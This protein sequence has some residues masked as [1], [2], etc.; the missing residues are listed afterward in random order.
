VRREGKAPPRQTRVFHH[1]GQHRAEQR[2]IEQQEER[3]ARVRDVHRRD[4]AVAEVLLRKQ[5][6]RAIQV[7]NK[8]VR[9]ER[10]SI[11]QRG[12]PGVLLAASLPQIRHERIVELASA[13]IEAV[14]AQCAGRGGI[15]ST[16][17]AVRA[18]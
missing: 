13:L 4:A 14:V 5:Q 17:P 16:S 2:R 6:R 9:C 12:Q 7:C 8:L 18:Y 15:D 10:L 11:R 1:R 3:A